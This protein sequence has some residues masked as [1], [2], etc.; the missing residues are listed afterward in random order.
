MRCDLHGLAPHLGKLILESLLIG[1]C[2]LADLLKLLL[3]VGNPLFLLR[4]MLQQAGPALGPL[5]Q[6]LLQSNQIVNNIS[7]AN[8]QVTVTHRGKL[9]VSALLMVTMLVRKAC[10]SSLSSNQSSCQGV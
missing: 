4:R 10:M 6:R 8:N 5:C 3:K 2:R 9:T 1:G 7:T